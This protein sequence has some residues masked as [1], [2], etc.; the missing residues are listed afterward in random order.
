[1]NFEPEK[2]FVGLI[3]FFA[4]LMPGA[5]L[6]FLLRDQPVFHAADLTHP[7]TIIEIGDPEGTF[8]W[9]AF[10]FVSYLLG[11]MCFAFG[12]LIDEFAYDWFRDLTEAG[13]IRRLAKGQRLSSKFFRDIAT[14]KY[15]FKND[16]D[17]AVRQ[18]ARLKTLSMQALGAQ[19]NT[20]NAYQ[21]SKARLG[22]EYPAAL[23]L[24]QRAEA[25]SKF[26]RTFS[27]VL[28]I[29]GAIYLWRGDLIVGAGCAAAI[30]LALWRYSEQR[31]K[32]TQT[33]YWSILS[34][35]SQKPSR[36]AQPEPDASRLTHAAGVV[37]RQKGQAYEFLLV[38]SRKAGS[39]E[40][41]EWVLP[42][43]HI[44]PGET[45]R[46]TAVREVLEETG[47]WAAVLAPLQTRI[48]DRHSRNPMR[49]ACYLM[50]LAE[51]PPENARNGEDRAIKWL[52]F[53]DAAT[54]AYEESRAWVKEAEDLLPRYGQDIPQS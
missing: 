15:A 18:V 38:T 49:V 32:G 4:V 35:E 48:L 23:A 12:A 45:A 50:A 42:K 7:A 46:Q 3:D 16:A 27:V 10:L 13:Q 6:A 43:G 17:A 44:E 52:P 40:R 53:S 31:F 39:G 11:H 34:I 33:A 24:V 26:F 19:P 30:L 54:L 20:I 47:C 5:A 9:L 8:G 37:V 51:A 2:L 1:M 22:A 36:S 28:L 21:W 29:A 14:S 25:D 41:P